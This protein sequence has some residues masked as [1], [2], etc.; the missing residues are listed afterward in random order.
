MVAIPTIV[1]QKPNGG[2]VKVNLRDRQS[3]LN[4]GYSEA[5]A[6]PAAPVR[7]TVSD[8]TPDYS[9][10]LKEQLVAACE[11]KD[12]SISGTKDELIARLEE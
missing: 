9:S 2:Q 3:Y 4:R 7:K 11:A 5:G 1:M 10:M 8:E 12:L 6:E